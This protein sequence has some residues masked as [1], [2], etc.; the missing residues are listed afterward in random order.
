MKKIIALAATL[1]LTAALVFAQTSNTNTATAGL[2]TNDVDNFMDVHD[3]NKVNPQ[4]GYWMLGYNGQYGTSGFQ[5]GHA[6][7]YKNGYEGIYIDGNLGWDFKNEVTK[8]TVG[9][10]TTKT[11]V[12]SKDT[13]VVQM[14]YLW[15]N[16]N[17][18]LLFSLY[19]GGHAESTTTKTEGKITG[20][21]YYDIGGSFKYGTKVN[22]L[23]PWVQ[24][25]Y[26]G[27]ID[28]TLAAGVLTANNGS[29]YIGIDGGTGIALPSKEKYTQSMSINGTL[30]FVLYPSKI[31]EK[32]TQKGKSSFDFN[33]YFTYKG[34]YEATDKLSFGF[35][36]N[37]VLQCNFNSGSKSTAID[38]ASADI[39]Y[40]KGSMFDWYNYVDLGL[41]YLPKDKIQL[42]AG[43]YINLPGLDFSSATS[44]NAAHVKTT[45]TNT[46][47]GYDSACPVSLYSGAAF[48]LGP[49]VIDANANI[50]GR[51]LTNT[52]NSSWSTDFW[53]NV[54]TL[55]FPRF[56]LL[57]SANF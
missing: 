14:D 55:V 17:N 7:N 43:A 2:F 30:G 48:T 13:T 32:T 16:G 8:T 3:W 50:L 53:T 9:E 36:F 52:L 21:Q 18:G 49:V 40:A 34:I 35:M 54:N 19:Y 46:I 42:N 39:P 26:L 22:N 27:Y 56:N 12:G 29:N 24:I 45:S 11:A 25:G 38:G 51:C 1:A 5:L 4:N 31:A 15:A 6:H 47:E 20:R 33:A 57:I 10:T 23:T 44:Y 41:K 28:K 37:S